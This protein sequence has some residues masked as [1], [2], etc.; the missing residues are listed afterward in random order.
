[1]RSVDAEELN[2]WIQFAEMLLLRR[3][4][5]IVEEWGEVEG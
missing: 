4:R 2:E 5:R 3:Q 1:V